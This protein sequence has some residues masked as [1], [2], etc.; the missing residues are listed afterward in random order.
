[1]IMPPF[2]CHQSFLNA[3]MRM[4]DFE[5]FYN[6]QIVFYLN[7]YRG[8]W[9]DL[10]GYSVLNHYNQKCFGTEFLLPVPSQETCIKAGLGAND[11]ASYHKA[12]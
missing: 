10:L 1:M 3:L 5:S 8:F 2:T 11:T 12:K 7:T 9:T 6:H 4:N